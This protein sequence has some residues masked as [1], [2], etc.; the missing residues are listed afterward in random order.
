[1][2]SHWLTRVKAYTE[3][4]TNGPWWMNKPWTPH[5][6]TVNK[7]QATV[8][9]EHMALATLVTDDAVFMSSSRTDLPTAI[10]VI[11]YLLERSKREHLNIDGE[12]SCSSLY[13]L[14]N[15]PLKCNC[16]AKEFN[17]ETAR[18]LREW[19]GE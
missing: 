6:K 16:E 10:K 4:A 17:E 18:Q 13:T 7:E 9:V 2:I 19:V 1:M 8:G 12:Y 15:H 11:E 5:P 3:R 14:N